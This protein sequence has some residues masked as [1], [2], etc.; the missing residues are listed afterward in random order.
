MTCQRYRW[1]LEKNATQIPSNNRAA[2]GAAEQ[3]HRGD[4]AVAGD[5][6]AHEDL[7]RPVA[8]ADLHH[9][10]VGVH[11][12]AAPLDLDRQHREAVLPAEEEERV[13]NQMADG[14]SERGVGSAQ[15]HLDRRAGRVPEGAGDAVLP[16]D[17]AAGCV[18]VLG[19]NLFASGLHLH[20]ADMHGEHGEHHPAN[21]AHGVR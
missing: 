9:F 12:W 3:E 15:Q 4:D 14:S 8:P 11:D 18:E 2:Y 6:E 17:V 20:G 5:R 16:A 7:V 13:S 21:C 19:G 1:H 10:E